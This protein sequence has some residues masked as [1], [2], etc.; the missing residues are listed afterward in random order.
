M[1]I[2]IICVEP[3]R[4]RLYR[5]DSHLVKRI[6]LIQRIMSGYVQFFTANLITTWCSLNIFYSISVC[7]LFFLKFIIIERKSAFVHGN[8]GKYVTFSAA[9]SC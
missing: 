6:N 4:H 3:C 5:T 2:Y 7:L 9:Y 8:K 1:Y